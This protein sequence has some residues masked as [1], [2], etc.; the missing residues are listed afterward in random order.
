MAHLSA[1]EAVHCSDDKALRRVEDSEE[2]L[3]EDGAAVGH[4]QDGRHPGERQQGQHHTGAPEGG[5]EDS[6]RRPCSACALLPPTQEKGPGAKT[7]ATAP[8]ERGYEPEKQK[9]ENRECGPG[10]GRG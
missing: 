3:E 4:G 7:S 9:M 10:K 2:G 1:Q 6:S 5:P 8:V